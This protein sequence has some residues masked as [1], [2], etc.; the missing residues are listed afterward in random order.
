MNL[1]KM[2]IRDR[3]YAIKNHMQPHDVTKRNIERFSKQ[4]QMLGYSFD[5]DRMVDTTD[6]KY[7]KMCIRDRGM[8][9]A[10]KRYVFLSCSCNVFISA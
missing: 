3:N 9:A 10:S 8:G 6:P 5:W 7:Y 2:C 4:L 1:T